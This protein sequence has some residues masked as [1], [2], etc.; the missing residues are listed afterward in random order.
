MLIVRGHALP[1]NVLGIR[2]VVD[3]RSCIGGEADTVAQVWQR[4]EERAVR[5]GQ[6][7]VAV[8]VVGYRQTI[9]SVFPRVLE[10]GGGTTAYRTGHP[11]RTIG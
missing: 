5:I 6:L 11:S 10:R 1:S 7:R 8:N 3:D 2:L 9:G 4:S